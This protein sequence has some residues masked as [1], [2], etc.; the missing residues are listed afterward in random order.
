MK[1][2][3][4]KHIHQ[5]YHDWSHKKGGGDG[6]YGNATMPKDW[7]EVRTTCTSL[8]PDWEYTVCLQPYSIF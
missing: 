3:I 5:V 1:Q 2:L 7:E 4:P 8:N 6:E